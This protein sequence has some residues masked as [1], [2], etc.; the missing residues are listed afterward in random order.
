MISSHPNYKEKSIIEVF[1]SYTYIKINEYE[2]IQTGDYNESLNETEE[3]TPIIEIKKQDDDKQDGGGISAGGIA[4]ITIGVIIFIAVAVVLILYLL[5]IRKRK[6]GTSSIISLD[7]TETF[8]NETT[9]DMLTVTAFTD[10]NLPN[11]DEGEDEGKGEDEEYYY[12][13]IFE[14]MLIDNII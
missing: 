4:G 2:D 12:S 5:V 1:Q 7:D 9:I 8:I 14:E 6:S 13:Y 10:M 11:Q 3:V